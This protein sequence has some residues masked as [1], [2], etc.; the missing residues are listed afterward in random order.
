MPRKEFS[1]HLVVLT[2]VAFACASV[3]HAAY[4][5]VIGTEQY[6]SSVDRAET[7]ERI[8]AVLARED[9]QQQLE[10]L[11]VDPAE[12]QERVSAL[13]DQELQTLADH[14]ENLPA[15]GS[16]LGVVGVV[17]IVLL[18]LELVGAI[19]IFKKI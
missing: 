13:T 9:V 19:D 18:V 4:G 7:L 3:Q 11:G 5:A 16:L 12:A 1:F 2:V 8:D 6:L 14:L 17:F 15:G 10:Q